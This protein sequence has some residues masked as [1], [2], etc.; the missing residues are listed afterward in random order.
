MYDLFIMNSGGVLPYKVNIKICPP[1]AARGELVLSCLL[2]PGY[3]I[4]C[5]CIEVPVPH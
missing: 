2:V 1:L 5:Q 3:P 4:P